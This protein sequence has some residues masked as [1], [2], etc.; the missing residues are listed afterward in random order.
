MKRQY[1]R[2]VIVGGILVIVLLV[3]VGVFSYKRPAC[4]PEKPTVKENIYKDKDAALTYELPKN[5]T[6]VILML[7]PNSAQPKLIGSMG[8]GITDAPRNGGQITITDQQVKAT[9]IAKTFVVKH[10]YTS[11]LLSW[12]TYESSIP[13]FILMQDISDGHNVM[14]E[15]QGFDI[16]SPN[17]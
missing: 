6:L 10:E 16:C 15:Y 14:R 7:I 12:L 13:W 4:P 3:L 11:K 9:N 5:T 8:I 2:V 1:R 17:T